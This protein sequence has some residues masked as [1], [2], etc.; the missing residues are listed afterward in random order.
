MTTR[1]RAF[2]AFLAIAALLFP[3]SCAKERHKSSSEHLTAPVPSADATLP[4]G[5]VGDGTFVLPN[6]RL[7][8]PVGRQLTVQRYPTSIV[9]APDG[10]LFVSTARTAAVQVVDPATMTILSETSLNHHFSGLAIDAAGARLWVAGGHSETVLEFDVTGEAPV[11]TRAIPA[12]GYPIGL[13]LSSDEATLY[14][15]M[16]QGKRVAVIDLATGTERESFNTGYYPHTVRIAESLGR[17][18]VSNWGTSSVSVFELSSGALLADIAVGKGPEG[19]A[20]APD[21]VTAYVACSDVDRID[22]VDLVNLTVTNVI[23]VY[24]GEAHGLG[25]MPT[26]LA[27]GPGGTPLYAVE[28]GFNAVDVIDPADG[29]I[30]GRVPTEWYPTAVLPT[31]DTIYALSAK[32]DG[33]G[34]GDVSDDKKYPGVLAAVPTPDA[35]A[36]AGYTAMVEANN[37]RTARFYGEGKFDSPIP[38]ERGKK[39]KQIKHVVFILKENKTFDQVMADLPGVDGD[40]SLLLYGDQITP[41]L[42]ALSRT[43]AM[44][45]N[46]YSESHESDHGHEWAT[47]AMCNDY[48]EKAW[49]MD[50]WTPLSGVEQGAIPGGGFAFGKLLENK[51]PFRVYGEVVGTLYDVERM[52]PY[53]DWAYGFFSLNVSDRYKAAE[54]IREWNQGVFPSFIFIS[55]PDDHTYGTD[56]GKPTMDYIVADNDAGLGMLVEW[57]TKSKYWP[58]TAIFII[59]DDPQSGMDHVD[60]H[61]SPL[62]VVSPWV[63]RGTITHVHYSMASVWQTMGR[64]IGLPAITDYDRFAAPMYDLFTTTPDYGTYAALPSNVPFAVNPPDAPMADYSA[65]QDWTVPD[66]VERISEVSWAYMKPG[67]P[68]PQGKFSTAPDEDEKDGDSG[69]KYKA[70][71]EAYLRYGREHGLIGPESLVGKTMYPGMK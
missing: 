4:A 51:I 41:N 13:T 24:S 63:K 45:D 23:P 25:A 22:V 38:S 31:A 49:A 14:V 59:E 5:A 18:I 43:F 1:A 19:L 36:L 64:I 26:Y 56:P 34:P 68:F 2:L 66:Q 71:M 65:K 61:R 6:G 35:D 3:A 33:A 67:Q 37:T 8:S 48:V 27:L 12:F 46:Y 16:A 17:A 55:L 32:G 60:A 44:G 57:V 20:L 69:R 9:A 30:L 21:G 39:S 29:T 50:G 28:S 15:T 62:T 58:E 54:V 53:I 42:H 10:R 11:Q 52:S 70:L 47:A 7:I 40:T